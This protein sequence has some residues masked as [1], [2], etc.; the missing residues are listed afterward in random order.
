MRGVCFAASK[1]A[2]LQCSHALNS[3]ALAFSELH[4]TV[5]GCKRLP[6]D[7]QQHVHEYSVS[8]VQKTHADNANKQAQR[9]GLL[10]IQV[11]SDPAQMLG[12]YLQSN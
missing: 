7:K 1:K 11:C 3:D 4:F 6:K 8:P 2:G 10:F 12:Q 5:H 9:E